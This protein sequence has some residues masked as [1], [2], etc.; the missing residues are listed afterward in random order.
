MN[1]FAGGRQTP[2]PMRRMSAAHR[3]ANIATV[4]L[5]AAAVVAVA[6]LTWGDGVDAADLGALAVTYWLSGIGITVGFHRL[7]TH[8]SF[9][10][11]R[12]LEL[13]FAVLGTMSAQG[14][15]I[16][17]VADHRKHHAFADDEGDPHS[18]HTEHGG[19]LHGLWH[20]HLGWILKRHGQAD[21]HRYAREMVEDRALRGISRWAAAIILGDAR[22]RL[23]CWVATPRLG[24]RR[25][26]DAALGRARA[27]L[28]LPAFR[29]LRREL[30]LSHVW[31]PAL[32]D[33]RPVH[34]SPIASAAQP[35]RGVA[36]QPPRVPA[37]GDARPE[38]VGARS[39]GIPNQS[40]L[41]R[42]ARA[43]RGTHPAGPTDGASS[44]Q[45]NHDVR[46]RLLG[47]LTS[48]GELYIAAR[49][50][51][52]SRQRIARWSELDRRMRRTPATPRVRAVTRCRAR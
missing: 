47:A 8:R 46:M 23:L 27:D 35:R 21:W 44:I 16:M 38:L 50:P 17:W 43:R 52:N 45:A 30:S 24:G 18:P 25:R 42:R 34:E 1:R 4:L 48:A 15:V 37:L 19:L 28:S 32:L 6:A 10:V 49:L 26:A 36:S 31:P 29:E 41:P 9:A 20:A 14:P 33:E 39:V 51:Q 3:C 7:L 22:D 2:V 12:W 13:T 11:P 40:A 5:P